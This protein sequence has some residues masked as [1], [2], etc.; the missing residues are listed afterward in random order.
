MPLMPEH[1]G[2]SLASSAMA[3]KVGRMRGLSV[4]E[5]RRI[6]EEVVFAAEE[7]E[8]VVERGR[9]AVFYGRVSAPGAVGISKG[10]EENIRVMIPYLT[11]T[12]KRRNI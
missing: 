9:R 12:S 4:T 11:T 8:G 1:A 5:K 6:K 3:V 7:A 2:P 10:E